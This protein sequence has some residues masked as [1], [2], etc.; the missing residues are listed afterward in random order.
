ML[1]LELRRDPDHCYP[2]DI[3]NGSEAEAGHGAGS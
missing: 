2:V 3:Y 1:V